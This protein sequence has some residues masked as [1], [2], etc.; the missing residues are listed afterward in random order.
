MNNNKKVDI[1]FLL[2]SIEKKN[3]NSNHEINKFL[4]KSNSK[5]K[6]SNHK[7]IINQLNEKKNVVKSLILSNPTHQRNN[8]KE[9]IHINHTEIEKIKSTHHKKN[10][11]SFIGDKNRNIIF[12]KIEMFKN[13][14]KQKP[15]FSNQKSKKISRS[16]SNSNL[17]P[18]STKTSS[19]V[20]VSTAS[21]RLKIYNNPVRFFKD[22][23]KKFNFDK[24]Q[25]KQNYISTESQKHSKHFHLI[26]NKNLSISECVLDK[27]LNNKNKTQKNNINHN[28]SRSINIKKNENSLT[29]I[30]ED[31]VFNNSKQR[32]TSGNHNDSSSNKISLKY[33][34]NN[35]NTISFDKKSKD[36]I[37]Y[38]YTDDEVQ[39]TYRKQKNKLQ[40]NN[41]NNNNNNNKNMTNNKINNED[42]LSFCNE[43]NQKLFGMSG[44]FK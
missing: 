16:N 14:K 28:L 11:S 32:S 36:S 5:T 31:S 10:I 1:N 24:K 2:N 25:K 9:L 4:K 35:S 8:S 37:D 33:S 17:E 26:N 23:L 19:D 21:K 22:D 38:T 34:S 6:I 27:F 42:F 15:Q 44:N 18:T 29:L 39:S 12:N 43:M 7:N 30:S 41:N 20:T 13:I 40:I 3:I